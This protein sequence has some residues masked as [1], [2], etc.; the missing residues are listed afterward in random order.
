MMNMDLAAMYGTPGGPSA[1]DMEKVAQADLFV[2][3]AADQGIDLRQY[4][5]AQIEQLWN[6]TFSKTAQEEEE[7]EKEEKKEEGEEKKEE[8]D[9][10][11]EKE[12]AARAEFTAMQEWREKVAEMD[13]LGRL[14]AHAFT[15]EVHEIGEAMEKEGAYIGTQP[16]RLAK[17]LMRGR[18]MAGEV[19]K[20]VKERAGAASKATGQH[21][22]RTGRTAYSHLPGKKNLQHVSLSAGKAKA[23]GA[24]L[25]GAG[26]AAAGGGGYAAGR[27]LKKKE[28]SAIDEYAIEA[29]LQKVAE[30]GFDLDEAGERINALMVL[31]A[32]PTESEKIASAAD[33]N[34]AVEIRSLELLEAAGY[35]VTWAQ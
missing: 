26:A 4:T 29:A 22:E 20:A 8:K 5:D 9:E 13:Y 35:P 31:G 15:Q 21:L 27:S 6:A 28:G 33:V 14:M 23:I 12:A 17:G 25:H 3:L 18:S 30:A 34:E 1:E 2:K 7:E 32:L 16:G 24:G 10:E 11:E 19:A